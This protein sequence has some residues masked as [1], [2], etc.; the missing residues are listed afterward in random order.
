[1]VVSLSNR[2]RIKRAKSTTAKKE[3]HDSAKQ[4]HAGTSTATARLAML[5][6]QAERI[7]A[8]VVWHCSML[9]EAKGNLK[10]STT[11]RKKQ[12]AIWRCDW[13]KQRRH[14]DT[15]ST[16][17][18]LKAMETLEWE[19]CHRPFPCIALITTTAL[20][21]QAPTPDVDMAGA[22]PMPTPSPM[23]ASVYPQA[24]RQ[25]PQRIARPKSSM[26]VDSVS[27]SDFI[28]KRPSTSSLVQPTSSRARVGDGQ[29]VPSAAARAKPDRGDRDDAQGGDLFGNKK[30]KSVGFGHS[31]AYVPLPTQ[32]KKCEHSPA[33]SSMAPWHY[34]HRPQGSKPPRSC[35]GNNTQ[36]H[37]ASSHR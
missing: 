29:L 22:A 5:T 37:R 35:L 24:N 17:I 9:S 10:R 20:H 18:V 25:P 26:E 31:A 30:Q 4:T 13:A 19:Q 21:K 16:A 8:T 27:P 12:L 3:Y 1:M 23:G 36:S 34:P 6:Q 15:N 33:V 2:K 14:Y 32:T 11:N 28:Q 7:L